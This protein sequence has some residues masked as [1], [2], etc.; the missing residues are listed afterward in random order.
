MCITVGMRLPSIA[1][2]VG[3]LVLAN[4]TPSEE[5]S[6]LRNDRSIV[7]PGTE[8]CHEVTAGGFFYR[9]EDVPQALRTPGGFYWSYEDVPQ[10][11]KRGVGSCLTCADIARPRLT[12]THVAPNELVMPHGMPAPR[13]VFDESLRQR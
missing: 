9:Y 3:S 11:F 5:L 2:A 4:T 8:N 10:E 7:M 6:R 13:T 1:V 12:E